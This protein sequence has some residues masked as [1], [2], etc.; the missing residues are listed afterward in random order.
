MANNALEVLMDSGTKMRGEPV[1]N[2]PQAGPSNR[3]RNGKRYRTRN[4]RDRAKN[5]AP[6]VDPIID[7]DLR[8]YAL[9]E[10]IRQLECAKQVLEWEIEFL[11]NVK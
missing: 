9:K 5:R 10:R 2:N 8:D 11:R 1:L 4:G 7:D 6:S 3:G